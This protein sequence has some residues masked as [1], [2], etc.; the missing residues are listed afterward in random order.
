MKTFINS[1][2]TKKGFLQY[3][4]FV[5]ISNV[6]SIKNYIKI[7]NFTNEYTFQD[8]VTFCASLK[9]AQWNLTIY[10]EF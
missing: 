6:F 7:D 10:R 5:Q 8:A 4:V 3:L 2:N 9:I 1:L